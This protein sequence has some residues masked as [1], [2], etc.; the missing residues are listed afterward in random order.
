MGHLFASLVLDGNIFFVCGS[1][2]NCVVHVLVSHTGH[3]VIVIQYTLVI[4]NVVV[5]YVGGVGCFAGHNFNSGGPGVSGTC[6]DLAG[7]YG[8]CTVCDLLGGGLA[9]HNP[10]DGYGLHCTAD[11]QVANFIEGMFNGISNGSA[12]IA[13][14]IVLAVFLILIGGSV[15]AVAGGG[16]L[17]LLLCAAGAGKDLLAAFGT[18]GSNILAFNLGHIVMMASGLN[19]DGF[20]GEFLVTNG[21]INNRLIGT[22]L[23]TGSADNIFLD[24]CCRDVTVCSNFVI[25]VGVAA[26]ASIG[27]ITDLFAGGLGYNR[28]ITVASGGNFAIGIGITAGAGMG[29]IALILAG[30]GSHNRLVAV[31][32]RLGNSLAASGTRLCSGTSSRCTGSMLVVQSHGDS[33]RSTIGVIIITNINQ[34]HLNATTQV[35][36]SIDFGNT[37]INLTGHQV[38][39]GSAKFVIDEH[40]NGHIVHSQV[41][42]HAAVNIANSLKQ[43]F[44]DGGGRH[45]L[46][47]F[48]LAIVDHDARNHAL[49]LQSKLSFDIKA[50]PGNT[51][52]FD[53]A[54]A[55][56]QALAEVI[57]GVIGIKKSFARIIL[58]CRLTKL[59]HASIES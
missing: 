29:G 4:E 10:G 13:D 54:T 1:F 38:D 7:V 6:G 30:G 15:H 17:F 3:A 37:E 28:C 57:V 24:S 55:I 5:L 18:G 8:C 36:K 58:R 42:R 2:Y 20:A 19:I 21:A 59:F 44:L 16:N 41:R 49:I 14:Y 9:V 32:Q 46:I 26:V 22:G 12:I 50:I 27:G 25:G 51:D 11:A 45:S 39:P 23:A 31:A 34:A 35:V 47:M 56:Q 33:V 43:V 48:S 52:L 40:L 53:V